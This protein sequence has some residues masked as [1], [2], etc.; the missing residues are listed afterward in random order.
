MRS[1]VGGPDTRWAGRGAP[2][3][4]LL[5]GAAPCGAG[6]TAQAGSWEAGEVPA[7]GGFSHSV[8]AEEQIVRDCYGGASAIQS[9]C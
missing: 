7:S 5:R 9:F 6:A 4:D 1:S 8:E 2:E 3:S